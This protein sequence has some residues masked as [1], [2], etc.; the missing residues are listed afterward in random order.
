M[1]RSRKHL[2]DELANSIRNH[3]LALSTT[4]PDALADFGDAVED[5]TVI[6]VGE[7]THRTRE[8]LELGHRFVRH[9]ATRGV[10]L[11]GLEAPFSET[12]ALHDYVLY[13]E[14]DP[15]SALESIGYSIHSVEAM[16]SLLQWIRRFNEGRPPDDR[17]AVYGFDV[18]SVTGPAA[19]LRSF[20]E[21][22]PDRD[23]ADLLSG[24]ETVADGVFVEGRIR[25][26]R[27][28]TAERLLPDLAAWFEYCREPGV[29]FEAAPRDPGIDPALAFGHFRALERACEFARLGL[30]ADRPTRWGR[31]DRYMAET[32]E[33]LLEYDSSDRMLVRA[34]ANHVK[35]GSLSGD[36]H[37]SKTMGE[38]LSRTFGDRYYALGTQ[39]ARGSVRAFVPAEADL[40]HDGEREAVEIDGRRWRRTEVPVPDPADGSIP[41][42][43]VATGEP[44]LLLDYRSIP[45]GDRLRSWLEGPR[46]HHYVAGNLDPANRSNFYRTHRSMAEFD[47][48]AFV[49]E[50]E[51]TSRL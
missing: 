24:L 25:E 22:H 31:R 2:D 35:R 18:Q 37:P 41:S 8:L 9:L 32:V 23:P 1:T 51:P 29:G 33:W 15:A 17:I 39:F 47:G 48:L 43:F 12:M 42:A 4:D 16:V 21:A 10:R 11:F 26:D 38:H 7:A 14:G 13:G 46:P 36:G 40:D 6:G 5:A 49:R 45:G 30:V 28:S 3:G 27:L 34:H 19:A 44:V 20:L 50:V